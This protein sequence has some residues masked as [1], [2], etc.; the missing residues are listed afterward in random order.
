MQL[1]HSFRPREKSAARIDLHALRRRGEYVEAEVDANARFG[2]V[3][4]EIESARGSLAAPGS[5][6]WRC[7]EN[8]AI[9]FRDVKAARNISAIEQNSPRGGAHV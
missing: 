3:V 1:T 2:S 5:N 8:G 4:D 7:N 6:A 9:H